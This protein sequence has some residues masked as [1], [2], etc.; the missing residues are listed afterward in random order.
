MDNGVETEESVKESIH[1][2]RKAAVLMMVM[3]EDYTAKAFEQMTQKEIGDLVLEMSS[4]GQIVPELLETV[5]KEFVEKFEGESRM[6]IETDAFVANVI[7]QTLGADAADAFLSDLEKKKL[8]LPFNWSRNI[9]VKILAGYMEGEHPQTIAMLLAHMPPEI[10][11]EILMTLPEGSKGDIA[12][13]I[14]KLGQ[15]SEEIVRDVDW[16]LK[17]ELS[18]AVGKAGKAG[19]LQ[20][21][22]DIINGV[23]KSTEDAVMDFVEEDDLK[24]ANDLRDL[25]F[26]FD[27]LIDIDDM[28]IREVLKKVEGQELTFALRTASEEMK[29]KIFSNLSKRAGEMLKDDLETMGPVRLAE[30]EEA[31][32]AIVRAAKELEA[33]GTIVLRKGK[34]DVLV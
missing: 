25:M 24:L 19:G 32:Q 3:G 2:P 33:A 21:L 15:I 8:D 6:F 23:D 10:S 4:V 22:V 27:D 14:A 28:A 20:V 5:A 29:D 13:R 7:K 31:Q 26:V 12:M 30:V 16:A 17:Y 11:S 9:N 18:G 34:D 1:G